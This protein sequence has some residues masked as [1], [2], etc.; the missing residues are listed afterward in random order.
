MNRKHLRP[1]TS[2]TL[3]D[4]F[5][6]KMLLGGLMMLYVLICRRQLCRNLNADTPG[7]FEM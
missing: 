5:K 1:L 7:S 4:V 6:I 2:S 3:R